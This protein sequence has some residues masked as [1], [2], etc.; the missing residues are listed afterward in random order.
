MARA[1]VIHGRHQVQNTDGPRA[2]VT[3]D[4]KRDGDRLNRQARAVYA[5]LTDHRWHTLAELEAVTG[6]PQASISARIRDLR[7]PKF[8]GHTVSRSYLGEGLWHYRLE[9]DRVP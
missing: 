2:G 7:K 9:P 3:F 5:I 1:T 6:Y 8:G 4:A